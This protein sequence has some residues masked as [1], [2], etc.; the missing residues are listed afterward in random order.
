M[1]LVLQRSGDLPTMMTTSVHLLKNNVLLPPADVSKLAADPVYRFRLYDNFKAIGKEKLID[2]RYLTKVMMAES[3][4]YEYMELED[5][6]PEKTELIKERKILYEGQKQSL[7]VFKYQYPEDSTWYVGISGPY[8]LKSKE[9]PTRGVMTS[10]LYEPY[11]NEKQLGEILSK[12][13]VDYEA[14]LLD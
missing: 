12:F 3:D 10:S 9:V 13:L 7:Y 14:K 11:E 1:M 8:I 2:S 4:L 6:L 5:A